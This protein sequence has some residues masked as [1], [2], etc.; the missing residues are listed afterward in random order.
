MLASVRIRF[1]RPSPS[2]IKESVSNI[3]S[4]ATYGS[5]DDSFAG[6]TFFAAFPSLAPLEQCQRLATTLVENDFG[7]ALEGNRSVTTEGVVTCSCQLLQK[8]SRRKDDNGVGVKLGG[9]Y[10]PPFR[11]ELPNQTTKIEKHT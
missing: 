9:S 10:F 1:S 8:S 5:L 11:T 4:S 7:K 2:D 3:S 6:D